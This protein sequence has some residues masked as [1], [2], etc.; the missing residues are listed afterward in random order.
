MQQ[1]QQKNTWQ[2]TLK[3]LYY[4]PLK[5]SVEEHK[6]LLWGC[7]H[8][9]HDPKWQE[10]IWAQRGYKSADEHTQGLIQNWNSKA[11]DDTVGFLLG[12]L[13]FG[14]GGSHKLKFLLGLMKFETLFVN[15][16]NHTAGFHQLFEECQ[17]NV[18]E[19][20]NAK[21]VVFCPNYFEAYLNGQAVV[22]SHYPI[23]SYNG[24]SKGAIHVFSHVHG[25]LER[26]KI[27]AAYLNSGVRA[28]EV[29]VE[30]N[31]YPISFAE[32]KAL[33]GKKSG[34]SFDH[35]DSSTQNPF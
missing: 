5:V 33:M 13:M 20:S 10:P 9:G 16:G 8:F 14:M 31:P 26:S 3:S 35:H 29:S 34:A 28:Y 24:Q 32:L 30:K 1:K 11:S 27:G 18:Y 7:T 23:I 21:R 17:N 2:D 4:K 6:I 25:N 15:S 12:D 22:L 19:F